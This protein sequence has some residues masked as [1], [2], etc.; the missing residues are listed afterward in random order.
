MKRLL[1]ILMVLVCSAWNSDCWT[2]TIVCYNPD[3]SYGKHWNLDREAVTYSNNA[4]DL[5]PNAGGVKGIDW[6]GECKFHKDEQFIPSGGEQYSQVAESAEST[7][8]APAPAQAIERVR[9]DTVW[10]RD[11]TQV[12]PMTSKDVQARGM[13]AVFVIMALS[14]GISII[15][16]SYNRSKF[17]P[18][19]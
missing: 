8:E 3:G 11:T 16:W 15:I 9:V 5:H 6:V 17:R 18:K 1:I 7:I 12:A 19:D 2:G 10:A 14:A 4:L 13:N